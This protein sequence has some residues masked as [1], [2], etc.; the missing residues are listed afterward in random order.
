MATITHIHQPPATKGEA[1]F[2]AYLAARGLTTAQAQRAGMT[3]LPNAADADP[4]FRRGPAISIP[5]MTPEG[6]PVLM[7]S[8]GG[9]VSPMLRVRYLTDQIGKD[10]KALRFHQP[11]GSGVHIYFPQG[12]EDI[13]WPAILENPDWGVVITEGEIKALAAS[14]AGIPTIA[15]GGVWNFSES[16]SGALHP[17][18]QRLAR[19]GR[20][21]FIAF[22]SDL[23]EKPEVDAA[24]GKL[25]MELTRAGGQV[26]GVNLPNAEDGSKQGL[27]DFIVA[28]GAD[29]LVDL[30]NAAKPVPP[31]EVFV[32]NVAPKRLLDNL[33]LMDEALAAS[34]LFVFQ[35]A[36][37]V[38][39]VAQTAAGSPEDGVRRATG[40]P[41]I[42]ELTDTQCVQLMMQVARFE[43]W[44]GNPPKPKQCECPTSLA[45][46]YMEKV[47]GWR[48]PE[49]RSLVQAPTLTAEGELI[50]NRG[51]HRDAG[52]LC[53]PDETFPE[54]VETPTHGDAVVALE[55]LRR[56]VRGFEF[57]SEASEAVW[58][59]ALITAVIR[60]ALRTAPLFAFSAP[61][62]GAG[63]TLAADLISIVATGREPAVMSQG[64]NPEEDRKRYLSVLLRGDPVIQI[65]NVEL[66]IEGDALCSILTSPIWQERVL[67]RSENV[68]VPTN[69]TWLA[70]GN[71][72]SFKGDMSTR[73]LMCRIMP[74]EERPEEREFS[75]DARKET[76]ETRAELVASALTIVRGWLAAGSP[77][78][79]AR[80][81]GRFEDFDRLVRNPLIWAGG[82]D[83]CATRARIEKEDLSREQ[84]ARVI[85]L[86]DNVFG[87]TEVRVKAFEDLLKAPAQRLA[88]EQEREKSKAQRELRGELYDLACEVSNSRP[89]ELNT[90][91]LGRWLA[92][93]Q[94]RQVDGQRLTRGMDKHEKVA[95]WRLE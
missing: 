4:A 67:G 40:A 46:H 44:S 12:V 79:N 92:K 77:K 80:P 33:H 34:Q 62:M 52:V 22:D 55:K 65:D 42:K 43:R 76:R 11:P 28:N 30:I 10:G 53:L 19:G 45:R 56:V 84:L 49:L 66:P 21:V 6:E 73:A 15:L 32:I 29:A 90:S 60:P 18:L 64:R 35:R 41:E 39:F 82:V 9:Q 23:A 72:L 58:I 91:K 93:H 86:W 26:Y 50:Q 37:R 36:G 85:Q 31:D 89:D 68:A 69:V 1:L 7:P 47:G 88:N 95:L 71:N 87:R 70:T 20:E 94:D 25:Y 24:R 57:E 14:L 54:I 63:K 61:V 17:D 59:A 2:A 5:Y 38:V 3:Y 83:P 81:F 8:A 74:K 78:Q 16:N 27:D 48:L 75:W 51:F 13:S